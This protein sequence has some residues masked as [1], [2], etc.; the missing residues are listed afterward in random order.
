M[1]ALADYALILPPIGNP[2]RDE[3]DVAAAAQHVALR[4][5]VEVEGIRLI[6]DLVAAGA[7]VSIVPE[8]AIPARSGVRTVM[9]A[10]IPPRRLALVRARGVQL[11]MANQAVHDVAARLARRAD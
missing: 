9:I 10:D 8:T 5:P 7:G 3:V 6:C 2:L 4:V 11:T 1:A